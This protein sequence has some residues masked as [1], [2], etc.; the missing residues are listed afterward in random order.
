MPLDV[1]HP[2]FRIKEHGIPGFRIPFPNKLVGVYERTG[3]TTG[4]LGQVL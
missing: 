3:I 1:L 2:F 4:R